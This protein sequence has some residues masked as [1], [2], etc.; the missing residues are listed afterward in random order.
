MVPANY[1][2]DLLNLLSQCLASR[3][4]DAVYNILYILRVPNKLV[5]I[6]LALAYDDVLLVP[7]YANISSRSEVN[8]STQITKD[9][10]LEIPIISINMDTVTGVEM[11]VALGKLGGLGFMPRFDTAEIQ[12]KKV[13]EVKK[14]KV[15]VAAALGVKEGYMERAEKL[16]EAGVDALTIDIAHGYMQQCLDATS[17]LKNRF[18]NIP[19]ISGVIASYEGAKNLYEAGADCVRVGLGPGTICTTRI[20]TGCGVPQITALLETARAAKEYKKTFLADGGTKNSGDVVKGLAT[21]ASAVVIG[22]QLAGTTEAPGKIIERDGKKYKEYNG[23]TSK[24]EK[25]KQIKKDGS[26]KDSNY[27]IHVEGVEALVPYKGDLKPHLEK[28]LA[29][30]RSGYSYCGAK[31]LNE[32]HKNAQFIRVTASGHRENGAHDVITQ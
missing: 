2:E 26:G 15:Q 1:I 16:V 7:Q 12:A 9:L 23:A 17:S 31:T 6:P 20:M 14:E 28:I 21:G 27:A 30:V 8:L 4:I 5:D 19:I 3:K 10:K 18:K 32:L 13:V 11:A 25:E 24:K 22:S 29:G